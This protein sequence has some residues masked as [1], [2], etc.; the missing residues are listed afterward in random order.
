MKI[1][2]IEVEK[3][4]LALIKLYK[5]Q[6]NVAKAL[7]QSKHLFHY[8]LYTANEIPYAHVVAMQQLLEKNYKS[9][10]AKPIVK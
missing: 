7:G 3:L 1:S 4:M 9:S 2:R 8:W 5:T 10:H 6:V